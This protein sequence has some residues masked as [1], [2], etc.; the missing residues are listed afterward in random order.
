VHLD[1]H[2]VVIN[3]IWNLNHDSTKYLV[4]QPTTTPTAVLQFVAF[5][6]ICS[7][8]EN[9]TAVLS[10]PIKYRFQ[11]R[12]LFF[13]IYTSPSVKF[14]TVLCHCWLDDI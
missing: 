1:T 14:C 12:V 5:H 4:P 3:A 2:R 11:L 8:A 6:F 10:H 7:V 9:Y 13:T